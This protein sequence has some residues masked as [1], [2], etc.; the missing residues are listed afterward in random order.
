MEIVTSKYSDPDIKSGPHA[1]GPETIFV[2]DDD[3]SPWYVVLDIKSQ[4]AVRK[5]I[6]QVGLERFLAT[7]CGKV[8]S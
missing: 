7:C 6:A 5:K 2:R 4:S 1:N 3:S 8:V